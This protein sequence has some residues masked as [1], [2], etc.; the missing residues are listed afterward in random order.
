MKDWA[1]ITSGSPMEGRGRCDG[2][3]RGED[4]AI[5]KIAR[6]G[7]PALSGRAGT[8]EDPTGSDIVGLAKDMVETIIDAGGVGLAAPQVH[9]KANK[10]TST[11]TQVPY[12]YY[13]LPFCKSK[14]T[15]S[16]AENVGGRLSGDT[17]TN[18]PYE[19]CLPGYVFLVNSSGLTACTQQ[20]NMKKDEQCAVLCRKSYKKEQMS[21]FRKMIDDEYRVHWLLDG[22]PVA[23]RNNELGY[24]TRGYP[25]GFKD[26]S[27]KKERHYLFNHVSITIRIH[28]D[29]ESFEGARVVGF[30]VV[31]Y[32]IKVLIIFDDVNLLQLIYICYNSMSMTLRKKISTRL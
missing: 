25:I 32:S 11:K 12:D 31:P 22:L 28:E 4:M 7:H 30:E 13:D 5:L 29:P 1:F 27:G 20:L 26:T 16:K 10:V 6:M 24:V 14:H 9:L 15:H 18:S 23:V 8:V 2:D 19:V 21:M 3:R 17:S